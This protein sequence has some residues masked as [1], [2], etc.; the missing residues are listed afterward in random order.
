MN[1]S[2][3]KKI[4]LIGVCALVFFILDRVLKYLALQ[5]K[6]LLVKNYNLALSINLHLSNNFIL[7]LYFS[8]F[9][10]L[11]YCLIK[12]IN[13]NNLFLVSCFLFFVI[14]TASNFLD[15]LKFNFVIDY[16]D[17]YFFYN[18][19]ADIF[20]FVGAILLLLNIFLYKNFKN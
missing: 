15:R 14:G 6:I 4:F 1:I 11:I 8:V 5:E 10:V 9:V 18:N 19:L 16:I 12:N 20:I 2:N 3:N 7:F 13:K 17:C